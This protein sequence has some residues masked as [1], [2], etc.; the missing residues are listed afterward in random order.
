MTPAARAL[1]QRIVN[2]DVLFKEGRFEASF[3]SAH[4]LL[5]EVVVRGRRRSD[6][7]VARRAPWP[8]RPMRAATGSPGRGPDRDARRD[9]RHSRPARRQPLAVPRGP[10]REPADHPRGAGATAGGRRADGPPESSRTAPPDSS[11]AVADGSLPVR[12]EHRAPRAVTARPAD[13]GS[14]SARSHGARRTCGRASL[15]PAA[16]AGIARVQLVS[17]RG[18]G[19]RQGAHR[20]C[21]GDEPGFGGSDRGSGVRGEFGDGGEGRRMRASTMAS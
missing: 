2:A 8:G 19:A 11:C 10:A 21:D 20:R 6:Q 18:F 7:P 3:E 17:P 14:R 16:R 5:N 13:P 12:A 4:A 1:A 15:V 9:P